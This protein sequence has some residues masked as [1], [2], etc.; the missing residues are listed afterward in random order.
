MLDRLNLETRQ[1]HVEADHAWLSLMTPTVSRACYAAELMQ[2]YGFEA[3]VE[4]ALAYSRPL[5]RIIE[6]PRIVRSG[7][8]A[9]DLLALGFSPGHVA[10]LPQC[11]TITPFTTAAEAFGWTY[12]VERATLLH[13]AL[14]KHLV[15]QLVDVR[16]A[17]SYLDT[18]RRSAPARWNELRMALDRFAHSRDLGDRIVEHA[19]NAFV[20]MLR[21]QR[22]WYGSLT[23]TA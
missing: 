16:D 7:L 17:F 10:R 21:W 14:Y 12:V 15:T 4:A 1:F 18:S 9:Q 22:E 20:V 13:D 5:Q 6:L 2:T 19:R 8:I 23:R 11:H 3:S